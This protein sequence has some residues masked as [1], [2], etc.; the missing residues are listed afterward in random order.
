MENIKEDLCF[1]CK[2]KSDMREV[3]SRL[4]LIQ[5]RLGTIM[6]NIVSLGITQRVACTTMNGV[7]RTQKRNFDTLM[8]QCPVMAEGRTKKRRASVMEL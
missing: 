6:R 4:E 1:S 8:S 2:N 5:D 7:K 3:L